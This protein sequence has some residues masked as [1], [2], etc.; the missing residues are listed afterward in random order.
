MKKTILTGILFYTSILSV[1][2]VACQKEEH[3]Q[4]QNEYDAS[5]AASWMN[6]YLRLTKVTPGFNSV[7]ATRA[8]AYAGLTLYESVAPGSKDLQS[9]MSEL[10]EVGK[11]VVE[12]GLATFSLQLRKAKVAHL[13]S[14]LE[15]HLGIV[16]RED[17]VVLRR[18]HLVLAFN[19]T[20]AGEEKVF[21]C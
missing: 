9:I 20:E 15:S 16:L 8:Y 18:D 7:V 3:P 4:K 1:L 11:N 21:N 2:L 17:F 12:R 14:T 19:A 5:V 13:G 10:I 6:L